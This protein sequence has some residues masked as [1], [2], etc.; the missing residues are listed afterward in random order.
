MKKSVSQ[1]DYENVYQT[2][3]SHP[4]LIQCDDLAYYL[5]KYK[6]SVEAYNLFKEYLA[7]SFLKVWELNIPD[8]DFVEVK[9]KHWVSH[10]DLNP[11]D[12]EHTCFGTKFSRNYF[13]LTDF[14]QNNSKFRANQFFRKEEIFEIALFDIW[15]ANED[16]NAGNPNLMYDISKE[17]RLVPIDHQHIFNSGC[18]DYPLESLTF[19]DSILYHPVIGAFFNKKELTN[20]PLDKIKTRYYLCLDKCY[21]SLDTILGTIPENWYITKNIKVL[22][23]KNLFSDTWKEETWNTFLGFLQILANSK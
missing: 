7:A 15:V 14:A 8:F 2:A 20:L 5:V 12:Y 21:Q 4:F 22:I 9:E 10:F 16:R 6:S 18:L 23:E 11:F 1:I 17:N 19:D 13:D 3:G